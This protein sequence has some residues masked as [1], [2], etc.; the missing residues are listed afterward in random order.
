[1][2]YCIL[3]LAASLDTRL[4]TAKGSGEMLIYLDKT[5]RHVNRSLEQNEQPSDATVATVMSMAIHHDLLGW[6]ENN[7][8]HVVALTKMIEMRGGISAFEG[9]PMLMQKIYQQVSLPL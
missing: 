1:V 4:G 6:H 5:Y 3:A 9:N 2:F 7:H 8:L